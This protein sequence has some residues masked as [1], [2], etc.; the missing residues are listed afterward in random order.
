M[1]RAAVLL[2]LLLV[3]AALPGTALAAQRT[4]G[5]VV[6][7]SGETVQDLSATGGTVIVRGTV[8]GDLHAYG[9]S[10]VVAE[11][12]TVTGRLRAYAGSVRIAGTVEENAVVYGGSVVLA[13]TGRVGRSFGAAAVDV[14]IA[15]TVGGDAA[16]AASTVTLG[17]S[18]V[19]RGDLNYNG[20]LVNEGGT[21]EGA[22][23]QSSDL[24]V[25]PTGPPLF[26]PMLAAYWLLATLLLGAL[27]LLAFPGF[28][29]TASEAIRGD[30]LHA[31]GVG[32]VVALGIPLALLALVVTVV[33][34]PLA[35]VGL[36]GYLFLLWVGGV[37]GRYALGVWLL[38]LRDRENRWGAL[39]VGALLVGLLGLLPVVGGV[40]R[41][42]VALV[43]AGA[44]AAA[45][46]QAY[47]TVADSHD[48]FRSP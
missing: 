23:R 10:V 2:A 28:S 47:G 37:Y 3:L 21:V 40:L 19:V 13:E 24:E 7:E 20:R 42:V 32:L 18:A 38:S 9:G 15:G 26:G 1:A 8:A 48:P 41:L 30:L 29:E 36:V 45:L 14:T 39:V 17:E 46:R 43:G 22:V 35:L 31:G 6:V 27:L 12:G 33:G 25:L 34:I 16:V 44:V 11:N 4:G 5:T